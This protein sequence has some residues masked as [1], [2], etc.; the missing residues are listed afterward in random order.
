M[1]AP[2]PV[3][4]PQ[5]ISDSLKQIGISGDGAAASAWRAQLR[6]STSIA[7]HVESIAA[8]VTAAKHR[9]TAALRDYT[10]AAPST[11]EIDAA[12]QELLAASQ[13]DDTSNADRLKRAEDKLGDL[14]A[15][16]QHAEEKYRKDSSDN[17]D[18]LGDERK[19]ADEEL[20]PE[21]QAKLQQLLSWLA[22]A[23][24]AAMPTGGAPAA[25]AAAGGYPDSGF[26][27]SSDVT[28]DS[29]AR[30]V[31][32]TSGGDEDDPPVQTHTSSDLAPVTSQPTL[33]NASTT[34][35]SAQSTP[36]ATAAQS[37]PLTGQS[38]SGAG[39]FV[40]PIPPGMGMSGAGRQPSSKS[41][42]DA[43]RSD[44]DLNR[45]ELLNGDDLLTR[46]VK[47]RL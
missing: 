29:D 35:P 5:A 19:S 41:D 15:R 24:A 11:T 1:S 16:R 2:T 33:I 6:T 42:E 31:R 47:G 37:G 30:P 36:V 34:A 39:G 14:L 38:G 40:P 4:D 13:E 9:A 23:P 28:A 17:I 25:P 26:S 27:P 43:S 21:A 22:A 46:S 8:A 18:R 7:A 12:Q 45:N 32:S 10:E 3:P 44:S 20:S